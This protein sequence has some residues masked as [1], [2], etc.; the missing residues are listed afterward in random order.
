MKQVIVSIVRGW[1]GGKW[2]CISGERATELYPEVIQDLCRWRPP[3][4]VEPTFIKNGMVGCFDQAA[5]T[6]NI[7]NVRI[8]SGVTDKDAREVVFV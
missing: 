7:P 3:G 5:R 4:L 1:V 6:G 2:G 8:G